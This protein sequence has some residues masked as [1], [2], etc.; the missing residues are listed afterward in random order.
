M[1]VNIISQ[2]YVEQ[3]GYTG[4]DKVILLYSTLMSNSK[5]FGWTNNHARLLTIFKQMAMM[6]LA[7]N[8]KFQPHCSKQLG[9]L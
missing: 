7:A 5:C 9:Q 4:S 6:K 2:V 1:W 8:I 3:T